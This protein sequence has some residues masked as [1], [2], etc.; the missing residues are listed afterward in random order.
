MKKIHIKNLENDATASLN[1]IRLDRLKYCPLY[2]CILFCFKSIPL[3]SFCLEIVLKYNTTI[4]NKLK[5]L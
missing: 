3:S 1:D 2:I 5:K 4:Y